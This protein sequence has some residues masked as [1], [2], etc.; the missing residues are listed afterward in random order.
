MT[1]T[2]A[3]SAARSA[4]ESP[5]VEWGARLGY[6]VLGLL[7][8]LI[9]W[10]GLTLAWGGGGSADKSG[11][12]GA[13]ASSGVGPA[14]LWV[15]VVG[16]GALALW[17][18]AEAVL[19]HDDAT[20]RAKAVGK[21]VVYGFFAW[22]AWKYTAGSGGSDEQQTDDVTR[23]VME[24][25]AGRWLVAAVGLAVIGVAA[26]HVRKGWTRA[27]LD[28]LRE[29]PGRWAEVSGRVGYLAKG[30]ALGVV[31][32]LFVVAAW[33]EDPERAAGLDGALKA[34]GE[35]PFGP[36]LLTAVALGIAAYGVYSIARARYARI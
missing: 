12:L 9:G 6:A 4:S 21:A 10:I 22:S 14:L 35:Q 23:T 13:M 20:H 28:D 16:F 24:Q 3:G 33:R 32:V 2:R 25:P 27:F 17:Q 7:H 8:L 15:A 1:T 29:H 18:C 31:G 19:T 36:L 30:V 26:Y 34:L 11:A 5:V